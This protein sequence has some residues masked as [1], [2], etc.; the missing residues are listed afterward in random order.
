MILH[1]QDE[2]VDDLLNG[3]LKV[4]Q[5]KKGYRFSLDALLLAHFVRLHRNDSLLDM[6]TGS[7]VISLITAMRLP[8]VRVVGID[9]QEDM[10]AM[11]ARSAA[12][13]GLEDRVTFQV[14]DVRLIRRDFEAESFD[15]VAFN[16][17][18]RKLNSGE[19]ILKERKRWP[20]MSLGY[21]G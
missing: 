17:P 21:P 15:A 8:D 1:R 16:P 6:G 10:I 5:K 9:V 18:Y 14:G 19:S 11:A 7:G 12:L 2:T 13:N 3:R 20:G 4:I